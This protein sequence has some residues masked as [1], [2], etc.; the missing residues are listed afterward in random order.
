MSTAIYRPDPYIT[1]GSDWARRQGIPNH[2]I[3]VRRVGNHAHVINTMFDHTNVAAV[4]SA[5]TPGYAVKVTPTNRCLTCRPMVYTMKFTHPSGSPGGVST[6]NRD[7]LDQMARNA[8]RLG[9]SNIEVRDDTGH[10]V[11]FE[12]PAFCDQP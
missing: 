10:D 2:C 1:A 6:T 8:L 5:G 4:V 12:I 7:S 3:S 9:L 11:T